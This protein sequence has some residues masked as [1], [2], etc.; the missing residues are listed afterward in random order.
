MTFI[1]LRDFLGDI[2]F[3]KLTT[4]C[5]NQQQWLRRFFCL[6]HLF[7]VSTKRE[8]YLISSSYKYAQSMCSCFINTYYICRIEV[9]TL[10]ITN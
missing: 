5:V 7:N 4:S 9:M 3:I 1:S 8:K 2:K 10:S 6:L